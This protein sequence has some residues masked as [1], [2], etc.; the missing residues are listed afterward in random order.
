MFE[1][2]FVIQLQYAKDSKLLLVTT[3]EAEFTR[4]PYVEPLNVEFEKDNPLKVAA[5]IFPVK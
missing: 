2:V 4:R 1:E 3:I 5:V